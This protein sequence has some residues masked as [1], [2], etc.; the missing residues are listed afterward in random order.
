MAELE[1]EDGFTEVH[2]V[3]FRGLSSH[4]LAHDAI[5]V[6]FRYA[7]DSFTVSEKDWVGLFEAD[8]TDFAATDAPR[9]R[10][11]VSDPALHSLCDG[12]FWR[13]GTVVFPPGS[14][15]TAGG[16]YRLVYVSSYGNSDGTKRVCG[17]SAA[18]T[19]CRDVSEYP[20]MNMEGAEDTRALLEKLREHSPSPMMSFE[21]L[22]LSREDGAYHGHSTGSS[23][24]IL[25]DDRESSGRPEANA[26]VTGPDQA[27][28][29]DLETEA[30]EIEQVREVALEDDPNVLGEEFP[31]SIVSQS[32]LESQGKLESNHDTNV[33]I[34]PLDFPSVTACTHAK[35]DVECVGE[36]EPLA[37]VSLTESTVLIENITPTEAWRFKQH[38][39]ELRQKIHIL[40]SKLTLMKDNEGVSKDELETER[41]LSDGL[42]AE[43]SQLT[44]QLAKRETREAELEEKY[45]RGEA[46]SVMLLQRVDQLEGALATVSEHDRQQLQ[47]LQA[48]ETELCVLRSEKKVAEGKRAEQLEKHKKAKLA[49]ASKEKALRSH[50]HHA[51]RGG[52]E[53]S[54]TGIEKCER[55]QAAAPK[56]HAVGTRQNDAHVKEKHAEI[57]VSQRKSQERPSAPKPHVIS[58]TAAQATAAAIRKEPLAS[59]ARPREFGAALSED[60]I[61]EI[62]RNLRGSESVYMCPVCQKQLT[63]RE[64]EYSAKLHIEHCLRTS[65]KT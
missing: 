42:R 38:N 34:P 51:K 54:R 50:H 10:V 39:K 18:L 1:V 43:I 2:F 40:I 46:A 6:S 44:D 4:Y 32:A 56:V 64:S 41:K 65:S 12:G 60:R 61:D 21:R 14:L 9:A 7:S 22:C 29:E 19:L 48:Y 3:E 26:K 8:A 25:A 52:H 17:K 63:S 13:R 58:T 23:F 53:T 27:E 15:P 24:L 47:R 57:T 49:A 45:R 20:S 5:H 36:E 59:H 37:D 33:E 11:N 30:V 62:T 16:A 55:P 28:M 31:E 35:I